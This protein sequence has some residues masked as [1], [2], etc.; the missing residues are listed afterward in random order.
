MPE[1]VPGTIDCIID[2]YHGDIISL[3]K[4]KEAGILAV[5][6]K[7]SE[8]ATVQDSYY[9][10]RR[11]EAIG[12]NLLWGAYHYASGMPPDKQVNNFLHA[13]QWGD[14]PEFD[15]MTLLCLDFEKS[16]SGPDMNLDDAGQFVSLLRDKTGR[17]PL[18][19]GGN[20][21]REAVKHA[22]NNSPV[23]NCPLW[24]ARYNETPKDIPTKFWNDFTFWQ[25]SDGEAG[26]LPHL[27]L[28]G[29][30][31]DRNCFRGSADELKQAWITLGT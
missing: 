19:Y 2:L 20:E 14:D 28:G 13:I 6:H 22:Q 23:R 27:S 5:I 26:P 8:G 9:A 11:H 16:H 25:Y 12:L 29:H 18:V 31:F 10:L 1:T 4:A 21:L 17:W 3:S 7:A 30:S 24:Y 15:K